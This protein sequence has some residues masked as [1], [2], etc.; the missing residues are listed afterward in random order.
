M[1]IKSDISNP[2]ESKP[3]K[4]RKMATKKD[5]NDDLFKVLGEL[6]FLG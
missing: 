4:K 2:N 6:N 3:I 1:E 5:T